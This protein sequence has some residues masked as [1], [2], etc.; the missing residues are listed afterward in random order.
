[1]NL[2]ATEDTLVFGRRH[3]R[4]ESAV[5]ALTRAGTEQRISVEVAQALGLPP[6]TELRDALG[7]GSEI[8]SAAGV[9]SMSVPPGG[10]VIF[11]P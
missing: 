3:G 2:T 4:G 1:M 9:L 5:V 6:G 10:A 11:A 8:V 7:G